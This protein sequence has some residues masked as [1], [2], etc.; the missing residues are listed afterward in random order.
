MQCSLPYRKSDCTSGKPRKAANYKNQNSTNG[1]EIPRQ[2]TAGQGWSWKLLNVG[3]ILQCTSLGWQIWIYFFPRRRSHAYSTKLWGEKEGENLHDNDEK[4]SSNIS[5]NFKEYIKFWQRS[6]N[7]KTSGLLHRPWLRNAFLI[8]DNLNQTKKKVLF[9]VNS[10]I[11]DN[12]NESDLIIRMSLIWVLRN[13]NFPSN[14]FVG[15][16]FWTRE[17][18]ATSELGRF[19]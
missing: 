2:N 1:Y 19:T 3:G 6:S 17:S 12:S 9:Q 4:F 5:I 15:S 7:L 14:A 16:N 18:C 10:T 11:S 13:R 8:Y